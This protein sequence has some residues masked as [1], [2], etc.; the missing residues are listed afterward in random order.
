MSS[1]LTTPI[2]FGLMIVALIAMLI[3]PVLWVIRTY[4][5]NHMSVYRATVWVTVFTVFFM[6]NK[7][8]DGPVKSTVRHFLGKMPLLQTSNI[9]SIAWLTSATITALILSIPLV[10]LILYGVDEPADV[11]SDF[12]NHLLR[13]K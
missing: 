13:L 10:T 6:I 11:I 1:W 4:P 3:K 9:A 7:F 8:I 12:V 5:S 2:L